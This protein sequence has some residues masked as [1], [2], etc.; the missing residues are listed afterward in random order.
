MD[1]MYSKASSFSNYKQRDAAESTTVGKD[2]KDST[3]EQNRQADDHFWEFTFVEFQEEE[4]IGID[5]QIVQESSTTSQ[6]T[7][8]KTLSFFEIKVKQKVEGRDA[9]IKIDVLN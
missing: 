6:L 5:H 2:G 7:M 3:I 1:Q 9:Q 4:E 8:S